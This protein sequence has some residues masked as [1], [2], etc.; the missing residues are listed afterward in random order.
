MNNKRVKGPVSISDANEALRATYQTT[1]VRAAQLCATIQTQLLQLFAN[2]QVSLA[3]PIESRVK[4]WRSIE[5]KIERNAAEFATISDITDLAGLRVILLFRQHLE[6]VANILRENFDLISSEDASTRLTEAQF[7]YQSQHY[8][9]RLKKEWLTVPTLADLGDLA[10]EVQVRTLAQHVW[11]AASHKLQYKQESSVPPP[12]RRTIHRVSA[13]L[14]TVDLELQRVFEERQAYVDRD[15]AELDPAEQLNVD[16]LA[17][18][19]SET[20]P[21]ENKKEFEDYAELLR[22]LFAFKIETASHLRQILERHMLGVMDL[23]ARYLD[24]GSSVYFAHVGLARTALSLEFG[25]TFTKFLMKQMKD[26]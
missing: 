3:I 6:P 24:D 26:P 8:I 4:S 10:A 5:E 2:E 25:D 19:L 16:L 7:G 14:E 12:L 17:A 9:V 11:A 18:I 13:L 1:S 21:A 15:V 22:D 20:F 23:E